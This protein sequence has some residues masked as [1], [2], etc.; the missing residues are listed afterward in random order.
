ML[1]CIVQSGAGTPCLPSQVSVSGTMTEGRALSPKSFLGKVITP[2]RGGRHR[3][4]D[5]PE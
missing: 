4:T 1:A 3:A 5:V 2:F